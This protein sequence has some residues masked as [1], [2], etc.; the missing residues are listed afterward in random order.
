MT[1]KKKDSDFA[2]TAYH[3]VEQVIK[4]TEPDD[5]IEVE[6][7]QIDAKEISEYA[8]ALGKIGG[9][10]GGKARAANLT[11]DQRKEIAQKA[12]QKRWGK[13]STNND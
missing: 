10:K 1:R 3:V 4:R 7:S 8:R 9:S 5:T 12:A 11:P 2:V 13:K 6:T